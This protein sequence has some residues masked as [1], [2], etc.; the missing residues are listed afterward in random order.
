METKM[1]KL[2]GIAILVTLG[3]LVFAQNTPK[4][5]DFGITANIGTSYN[6]V[7][8]VYHFSDTLAAR[9]FVGFYSQKVTPDTVTTINNTS[10]VYFTLGTDV[11]YEFKTF[12]NLLLGVGGRVAFSSKTAGTD[13]VTG[14]DPSV[15]TSWFDIGALASLQYFLSPNFGV[16]F[17][18]V[19][20]YQSNS[21]ENGNSTGT[22]DLYTSSVGVVVYLK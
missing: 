1:K 21:I 17:D 12:Q 10:T 3:A 14:T 5:K 9:P 6:S 15:T 20:E 4:A 19:L 22:F 16:Y 2:L 8:A 18:A 7:G 13:Y 11:L